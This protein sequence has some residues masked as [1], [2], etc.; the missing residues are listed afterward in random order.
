MNTTALSPQILLIENDVL[1]A[2]PIRVAL[3][4][5]DGGSFELKW[6]HQLSEGLECLS[7]DGASKLARTSG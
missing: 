7:N 1:T 2:D 4:A 6:V 3:A 5:A